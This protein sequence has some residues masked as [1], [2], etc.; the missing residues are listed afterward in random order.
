MQ[1][2]RI[3][4]A[5][6][7]EK[8]L[9]ENI[10]FEVLVGAH[11]HAL[12]SVITVGNSS[13]ESQ[14]EIPD[15]EFSEDLTSIGELEHTKPNLENKPCVEIAE[16][17][18]RLVQDEEREKGSIESKVYWS[19]LT[20]VKGGSLVPII[21]LAQTT[22]Q[23]LQ[24]ASN[25]WMAWACSTGGSELIAGTNFILLFNLCA[26]PSHASGNCRNSD[27][28]KALYQHAS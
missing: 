24:I 5:G 17:E 23:V 2:G 13:K 22:F 10:G 28:T 14:N 11:N 1:N 6:T 18:A 9:K 25:Y 20:I 27:I 3:A 15:D 12:E 26:D 8:L 4:Q 16:K 19:Y 7:F 21:I